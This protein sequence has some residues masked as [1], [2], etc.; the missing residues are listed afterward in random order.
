MKFIIKIKGLSRFSQPRQGKF[1][2]SKEF[3]AFVYE[4]KPLDA[5]E[6]NKVF[7]R[8]AEEYNK[9]AKQG[10]QEFILVEIIKDATTEKTKKTRK[11]TKKQTIT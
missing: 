1:K 7:P 11:T 8:L 10:R 9:Y 6:F 3:S 4:G 2:Y 5:D